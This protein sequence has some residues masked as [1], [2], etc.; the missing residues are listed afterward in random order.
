MPE[1]PPRPEPGHAGHAGRPEPMPE[2]DSFTSGEIIFFVGIVLMIPLVKWAISSLWKAFIGNLKE[3]W[4]D[5]KTRV[6]LLEHKTEEQE[7]KFK[8]RPTWDQMKEQIEV[9]VVSEVKKNA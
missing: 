2:E 7:L 4:H 9:K 1:H 3:Q 5:M 6:S 8:D